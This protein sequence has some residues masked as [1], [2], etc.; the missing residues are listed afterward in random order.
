M[1]SS[2]TE[3]D[4]LSRISW[5]E[6]LTDNTYVDM[7]CMD[8]HIINAILA[9]SKTKSGLIESVSRSAQIIPNEMTKGADESSEIDWIKEQ[10]ADPNKV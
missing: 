7:E 5:P 6:V 4:A 8:T 9:G 1:W 2:N 3:A 10:R